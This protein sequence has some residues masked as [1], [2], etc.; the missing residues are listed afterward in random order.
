M[1]L[2]RDKHCLIINH[3]DIDK[4]YS[5]DNICKNILVDNILVMFGGRVFQQT[6]GI[7][8]GTN[9]THHPRFIPLFEWSWLH[10]YH[11]AVKREKLDQS[12]GFTFRFIDDILSPNTSTGHGSLNRVFGTKAWQPNL[13]NLMVYQVKMFS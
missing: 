7:P 2:R 13:T 8:L 6:V 1:V 12:F 9:C 4:K 11:S 10:T 3:S 5:G